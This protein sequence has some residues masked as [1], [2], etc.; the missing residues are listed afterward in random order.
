MTLNGYTET[1]G[2]IIPDPYSGSFDF[3]NPQ[4]LNR[5]AYVG[6]RPLNFTD[7][8]GLDGENPISIAGGLGGCVGA[9]YSKGA[10]PYA[11][12]GCAISLFSDIAS[13]FGYHHHLKIP[14]QRPNAQIWDEYHVH[15]GPNIAS[16]GHVGRGQ[17]RIIFT[18]PQWPL[19]FVAQ[20]STATRNALHTP[21]L[22]IN[23]GVWSCRTWLK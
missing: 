17:A 12:V 23:S 4:S 15:Y 14:K 7:P 19:S 5:Y 8:S 22:K 1:A 2:Y 13:F 3:A 6:N 18:P 10:N 20:L 9:A 21:P 16:S 11:D